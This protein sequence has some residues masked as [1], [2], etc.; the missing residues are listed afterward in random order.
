MLDIAGCH[1]QGSN[2]LTVKRLSPLFQP[3][4]LQ[5]IASAPLV[6]QY[7]QLGTDSHSHTHHAKKST[8]LYR[9][10]RQNNGSPAAND[11]N[12]SQSPFPL[13]CWL[14]SVTLESARMFMF[15]RISAD[16]LG[17]AHRTPGVRSK[18]NHCTRLS[19]TWKSTS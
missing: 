5:L 6:Q 2:K 10:L 9:Q 7:L 4:A 15:Q 1:C 13:G 16:P 19:N 8:L 12:S 14:A 11:S 17:L 18:K 3:G